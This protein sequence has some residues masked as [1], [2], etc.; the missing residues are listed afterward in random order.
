MKIFSK[1]ILSLLLFLISFNTLRAQDDLQLA[2]SYYNQEQYEKAAQLFWHLYNQRRAKYYF[3][4]YVRCLFKLKDYK[5]AERVIK[6]EIKRNPGNKSFLIDLARL[7][8]LEGR[9][10][11]ADRI[12]KSIINNPPND[13]GQL[14]S[15]GNALINYK[16]YQLAEKLYLKAQKTT[17]EKFYNELFMIYSLSR[18]TPRLIDVMLDWLETNPYQLSMVEARLLPYVVNDVNDE[19]SS[20]LEKKTQERLHRTRDMIFYKLLIWLYIEKKSLTKA[21]DM[22]IQLDKRQRGFGKEVFNIGEIARDY[23]SLSLAQKAFQYLVKKGVQ[24]PFY[25]QS[26]Q[27]LLEIYY[28]Q[29]QA[30]QIHD[31]DSVR[32]IENLYIK[33]I[34]EQTLSPNTVNMVIELAH[35]ESFY[36]HNPQK[37]LDYLDQ[38]LRL[39]GLTNQMRASLLLEKARILLAQNKPWQAIILFN[40]VAYDYPDLPASLEAQLMQA[41]TFMYIG[42]MEGAKM[43]LDKIKGYTDSPEANDAIINAFLIARSS[44]DSTKMHILKI[45]ARAEFYNY[46]NMVDSASLYYD[47]VANFATFLADRALLDK[48]RMLKEHRQYRAAAETLEKLIKS[49]AASTYLDQA[50]YLAAEIYEKHL[51]DRQKAMEYYKKILFEL[52]DSPLVP[53]AREHYRALASQ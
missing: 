7:Y 45:Y 19:F 18:N 38:A 13:R 52:R 20:A 46:R 40:K 33:T 43:Y 23:D 2:V 3:D 24:Y 30:G 53:L 48:A 31:P 11:E 50:Y 35:L 16:K 39:N 44:R 51:G 36:L 1:F 49:F 32:A 47:S 14:V 9:Q 22:A 12:Y 26:Q 29:I 28:K 25:Q 21:L 10:S 41:K 17:G 27:R 42:D 5:K 34:H 8:E 37:G 15:I 6:R 4:Y